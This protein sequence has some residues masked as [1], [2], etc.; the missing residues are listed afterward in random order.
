MKGEKLQITEERFLLSAMQHGDLKAYGVLFRRYYP[1]LCAYATKFVEL[2][3][4]EE[5]VQDVML[6]LWENRETQTFETSLSQYLFK[7]VYHRAINQIVR[8][9]S[10]LRADTLFYENMQE[11]LQD[12]DFY[13][14]EELQ[15]RI[16]E[17]VDALPPAY[18][19]A[20]VMHR[21]DNKSYKEIAEILQV[22]PKTVDYRIQQALKQLRITLK[23]YL[24][25]ILLLLP[26]NILS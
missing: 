4:A 20:F 1:I 7:T 26:R 2:K 6:W 13:Q 10:Q 14:L 18:R 15:R 16:R 23:D 24:P 19:E 9:Q 25:L 11:M 21:F 17:A 12:T 8:H 22:S 3:D 5:I